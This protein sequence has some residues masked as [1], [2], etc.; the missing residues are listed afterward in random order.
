[1][2]HDRLTISPDVAAALRDRRPIVA[3]ESTL[4]SHG[5]PYPQN[6]EVARASEAAVR[7]GGAVPATVAVR[8]G[9]LLVGLAGVVLL[10]GLDLG[11]APGAGS[12]LAVAELL[13][14]AAFYAV[15]PV[16]VTRYLGA[17]PAL[18]VN[19]LALG[20]TAAVYLPVGLAQLPGSLPSVPALASTA[21]LGVV[22]TAGALLVFFALIAE[23]GSAAQGGDKAAWVR[24]MWA[25]A[26]AMPRI[27]AL[28]WFDQDKEE[29]WRALPVA[30]AFA[31]KG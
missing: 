14:A 17:V 6:L 24:D 8:D 30:S 27:E 16:V 7:A 3:L 22:C 21:A 19:A 29:D 25:T 10:L 4:I 13:V 31:A 9:R 5:L 23:V 26:R 20:A 28:V 1:M 11:S 18:G 2:I 15:G 12:G